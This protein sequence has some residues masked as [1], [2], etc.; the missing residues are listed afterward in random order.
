L[1]EYNPARWNGNHLFPK[2]GITRYDYHDETL[3]Y[4]YVNYRIY[5]KERRIAHEF[6]TTICYKHP[7]PS[8]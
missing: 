3:P 7:H 4:F 8:A 6:I 2:P 1:C 5:N